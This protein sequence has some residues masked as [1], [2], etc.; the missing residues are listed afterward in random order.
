MTEVI[1]LFS[2]HPFIVALSYVSYTVLCVSAAYIQTTRALMITGSILGLPAV[3]MI[4]MSMPCIN[5]GQEPQ[6]SKNKRTILGGVLILIVGK[7][8]N[9]YSGLEFY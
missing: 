8:L 2:I 6:S 4:L 3:G 9:L 5:L 1:I 7:R